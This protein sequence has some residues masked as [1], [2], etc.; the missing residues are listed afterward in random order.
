MAA[1]RTVS[2]NHLIKKKKY[3]NIVKLYLGSFLRRKVVGKENDNR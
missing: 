2:P 1:M 3:D